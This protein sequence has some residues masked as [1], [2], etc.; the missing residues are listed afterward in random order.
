MERYENALYAPLISDWSNYETWDGKGRPTAFEK[1]NQVY[2]KRWLN[3][4]SLCLIRLS[5]NN[6]KL[7]SASVKPP[8]VSPP[9]FNPAPPASAGR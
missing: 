1:A 9:T 7:S 6:L 5:T 8:A 4:S 2:K 3:I